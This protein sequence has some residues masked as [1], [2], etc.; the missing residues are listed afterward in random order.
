MGEND[1]KRCIALRPCPS[2]DGLWLVASRAS[3]LIKSSG[4]ASELDALVYCKTRPAGEFAYFDLDPDYRPQTCT[5]KFFRQHLNTPRE[6]DPRLRAAAAEYHKRC[7]EYDQT[8]CSLRTKEGVAMPFNNYERR[9]ID[10]HAKR[11]LAELCEQLGVSQEELLPE[12]RKYVN[13]PNRE[14]T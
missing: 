1:S 7:E 8:V 10:H 13:K 9:Q 5:E 3:G 12:I 2:A 14:K 6:P 4:H 11:V